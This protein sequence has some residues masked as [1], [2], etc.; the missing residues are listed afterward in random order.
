MRELKFRI[1]QNN[2]L[3]GYERLINDNWEWM[4]FSTNGDN[5]ENWYRGVFPYNE[6][7]KFKYQ[8]SQYTGLKDK[9]GKEIFEGDIIKLIGE[10]T[11][12]PSGH[13]T[14]HNEVAF[15]NGCFGWIGE[16]TGILHSFDNED[17]EVIGNIYEHPELL[18]PAG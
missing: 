12:E 15:K 7:P 17:A 2:Q 13:W 9:N 1:F 10:D 14:T 16:Q 3:V 11:Q 4:S 5:H 18:S 6:G 8:R